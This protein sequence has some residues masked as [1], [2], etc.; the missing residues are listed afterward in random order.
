ML[1]RTGNRL[2]IATHR[3]GRSEDEPP[4]GRGTVRPPAG[5]VGPL[6]CANGHA[7][8][9]TAGRRESTVANP[10]QERRAAGVSGVAVVAGL[11][12]G[13]GVGILTDEV[14][15]GALVGLGAGFIGMIVL[16]ALL[17]DW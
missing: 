13:L 1:G 11:L 8:R 16:R 7:E 6:G 10:T 3:N 5:P 9:G 15:A 14:A 12:I 17:G 2:A 4:P